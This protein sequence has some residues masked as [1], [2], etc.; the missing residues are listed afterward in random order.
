MQYNLKS[1]C[2]DCPFRNDK[3]PFITGGRA[4]EILDGIT[5]GDGYFYCH[6]YVE[7]DQEDESEDGDDTNY[8]GHAGDQMCAGSMIMLEHME[9]PNQMMRIA[10]RL[11][12]YDHTKMD[13]VAPVFKNGDDFVR[14]HTRRRRKSSSG[15]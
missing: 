7:Y 6:K 14:H 2:S 5:T 12:M 10:E 1:P 15:N 3:D 13:M 11:R 9:Q 4:Q 8:L